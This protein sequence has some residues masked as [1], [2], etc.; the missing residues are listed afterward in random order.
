MTEISHESFISEL[1]KEFP[2][3]K[4][5][6]L[7]EANL[8][9]LSL[10][11][12][13]FRRFVQ[14]AIDIRDYV[15]VERCF[16]FIEEKLDTVAPDIRNFLYISVLNKLNINREVEKL[17]HPKLKEAIV[18]LGLYYTIPSKNEKLNEFLKNLDKD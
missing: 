6:L 10:Q 12:G 8:G 5:D 14:Q 9:L 16:S 3:M 4:D 1:I 2:M 18:E 11:V 13:H 7:D 15:T 17:I